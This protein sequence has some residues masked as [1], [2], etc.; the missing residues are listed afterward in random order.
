MLKK[1]KKNILNLFYVKK[2]TKS[3]FK[4]KFNLNKGV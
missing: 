3:K 1:L 2:Q 4:V